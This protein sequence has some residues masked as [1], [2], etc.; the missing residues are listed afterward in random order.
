[1]MWYFFLNAYYLDIYSYND[2]RKLKMAKLEE[3]VASQ[4]VYIDKLENDKKA[5][6]V[7]DVLLKNRI[8]GSNVLFRHSY[9]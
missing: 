5:L 4:A 9:C 3:L 2:K 6:I 1:M 7:S 8:V